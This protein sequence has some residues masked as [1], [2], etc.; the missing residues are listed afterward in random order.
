MSGELSQQRFFDLFQ[1]IAPKGAQPT[2]LFAQLQAA[3]KE[4]QRHYHT[5]AHILA[6]LALFDEVRSLA[7]R[8]DEVELAIWF[9]D[10]V[11]DPRAVDNEEKSA[12]WA[13]T[14]LIDSATGSRVAELVLATKQHRA[15]D[16]DMAL[17]L[18]IDLSILGTDEPTFAQFERDIRAEYSFVDDAFYRS[19]RAQVLSGFLNRSQIFLTA[20]LRMR[21]EDRARE[22]ISR[23]LK[24]LKTVS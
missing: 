21:F 12:E 7:A 14:A 13:R 6:C 15:S 9:H 19:G 10:A 11:Y 3:Y 16:D 23:A 17:L 24:K 5:T 8:P 20:S 2:A 18:D 4:A 22:N 1:R